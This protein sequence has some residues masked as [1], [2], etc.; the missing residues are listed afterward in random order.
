MDES[1]IAEFLAGLGSLTQQHGVAIA[2]G[3]LAFPMD[4]EGVYEMAFDGRVAFH[5]TA[6]PRL[7]VD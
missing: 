6:A 2:G 5:A 7:S 3:Q 4:C 1:R